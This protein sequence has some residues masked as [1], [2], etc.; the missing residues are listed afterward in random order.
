MIR[1][2]QVLY[3]IDNGVPVVLLYGSVPAW[4]TMSEGT[5]GEDVTQLNH[6]LVDLGYANSCGYQ[7]AGVGLL[8]V[9]DPVRG[10]G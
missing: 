2:G 8:L 7:R 3:R 5:T 1:Q 6:D 4:R 10:G 9:G